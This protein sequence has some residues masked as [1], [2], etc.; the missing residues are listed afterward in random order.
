MVLH[1]LARFGAILTQKARDMTRLV[2]IF[3]KLVL[4]YL[5]ACLLHRVLVKKVGKGG[6]IGGRGRKGDRRGDRRGVGRGYKK[7]V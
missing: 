3:A 6:V 7:G 2:E 1:P 4:T 5:L